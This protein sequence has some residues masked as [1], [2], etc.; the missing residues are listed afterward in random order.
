[1][2]VS[3]ATITQLI[4]PGI[5]AA[6]A[7][8]ATILTANQRAARTLHRAYASKQ[9]AA[10]HKRWTPPAIFALDTWLKTL[11]HRLLVTGAADKI[12]LNPA[13][14]HA[15]WRDLIAADREVSGL[16]SPDSLAELAARAW[17]LL[18]MANGAAQL[19]D[20]LHTT[21][22]RAFERWATHFDRLCARERYITP[23]QL[24]V[25]LERALA[26]GELDLPDEG[27][28]LV[29]FDRHPP[30][31]TQLLSAIERAGYAV[32]NLQTQAA[33][34]RAQL[35]AA[36][37][38]IN[39]VR[40]AAR[41]A[42]NLLARNRAQTIALVVPNLAARRP[43]LARIFAEHLDAEAFEFSLG[44]PLGETAFAAEA[45]DL[46]RW[47]LHPIPIERISALLL[48]RSLRS[49]NEPVAEFDAYDLR[50]AGL[51]RPE[52]SLDDT[53][54]LLKRSDRKPL[55]AQLH[56]R[57]RALR[58]AAAALHVEQ[59]TH[60]HWAAAFH[61]LLEAAGYIRATSVDSLHFQLQR[62]WQSAL[63]TMA[64][65][66]FNGSRITARQALQ[67][68]ERIAGQ[69]IFAPQSNDAPIQIVGPLEVGAQP[70]DALWFLSA[71]DRNW[72]ATSTPNPLLP[73]QLQRTL[74]LAGADPARDAQHAQALTQRIAQAATHVIFSYATHAD[75]APQRP[76]APLRRLPAMQLD[77]AE[78]NRPAAM[79]YETANDDAP[80]P[81]LP[82]G[83]FPGG[84][85]VLAL[86]AACPF[87][88]FA[89]RRLRSAEL[90]APEAGLD[91]K[92][93]GSIVH[94]VMQALW[95][96]LK[97]Q[98][99]LRDLPLAQRHAYL[100]ECID[101]ALARTERHIRGPWDAAYLDVQRGRLRQLLQPWLDEELKRPN[102]T[103]LA[104]EHSANAMQI[105][106][107]RLDLRVDRIDQTPAGALILDY[108]TSEA[109]PSAW[110]GER[111][112]APQLPLYAVLAAASME[113]VGIASSEPLAGVAFAQLRAG[114][115]KKLTGYADSKSVFAEAKPTPFPTLQAQLEEWHRVLEEL[116]RAFA[117]GDARV[118]PKAYP[119]TCRT[120]TQRILC[121]LDPTT[122]AQYSDDED[123][124]P[125]SPEDFLHG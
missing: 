76:S 62:R 7:R 14:Q 25:A 16:R 102:F 19:R 35:F 59:D 109:T 68:L 65:L 78:T 93:R 53:I 82:E 6:I 101:Q 18:H 48:S 116:A 107:L 28:L 38:P 71:D 8:G 83:T 119:V 100:D 17:H 55:L 46:L 11:W 108:K 73:W 90:E 3:A 12:L 2:G 123:D 80:L 42:S 79:P 115:D 21:D 87:R 118:D 121:R 120:C 4:A 27:I 63:D 54:D 9:Q 61:T 58:N 51:L 64:T 97:T 10:G 52:L 89:E 104:T 74:G 70:F 72:P 122:L 36:L 50:R 5:A 26:E 40:A 112:D 88:A 81:G 39:E 117:H 23:A 114:S 110:A 86:Q 32:A 94:R 22:T 92:D 67:R 125:A 60:L 75:D 66:D 45:L 13:Q 96:H 47:S 56:A 33:A 106:P 43:E 113:T 15:L 103:V 91:A 77:P 29:D 85:N 69:T 49:R 99:A 34:A 95:D 44:V 105:G 98:Q 37:D 24:P 84:A 124:F 41:W 57:L 20:A 111:P 1:M 31:V 30:A